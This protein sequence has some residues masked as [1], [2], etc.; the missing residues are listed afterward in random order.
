MTIDTTLLQDTALAF[1]VELGVE[2]LERF[3]TCAKLLIERNKT[4][5][6]TSV[7]EPGEIV[8]KHFADSLSL[9]PFLRP[10][11]GRHLIDV[12]TGAG[13]PGIPLLIANPALEITFLDATKKKVDFL[14]EVLRELGLEAHLLCLRAEEAG[15]DRAHR[16][17][18]DIAVARAVANLREL[19]EYCLPLVKPGGCFAAMKGP[20][21]AD[22]A[23][24][25][26]N[27]AARLGAVPVSRKS[28]ILEGAGERTLLAYRKISATDER[29]PRRG[30]KIAKSPL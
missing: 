11:A 26:E 17:R 25:A 4:M 14:A 30:G 2:A 16:D 27:A 23:A 21:G 10:L 6:L 7:T 28:F 29:F 9:I 22:E 24:Q 18:Y 15:R 13:F 20:G 1:G 5:N 12:G 8:A 19:C 3:D